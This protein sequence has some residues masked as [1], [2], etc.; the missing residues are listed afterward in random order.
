MKIKKID[1]SLIDNFN[2]HPFQVNHDG[3]LLELI[4]SIS[5]SGLLNPII[6]RIKGNRYEM[7]S[8]HR[9]KE[10]CECLGYEEIDA[11]VEDLTDDEAIIKMVDSNIQRERLLPSEK[12]FAYKMKMEALKHQGKKT[13]ATLLHKSRDEVSKKD[14]GETVRKY[15]RLTYLIPE[16][17]E[18]IDN[19][20]LYDKRQYLTMGIIIGV[21]LSYLSKEEQKLVY[22]TIT[23]VDATPT[24]GQAKKI[25][26][27][28]DNRTIDF[29]KLEQILIEKK[30]IQNDTI[31]FNKNKIEE[32]LPREILNRDKKY[33]ERYIIEAIKK[34]NSQ[35][36]LH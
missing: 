25:R 13:C 35:I 19:T 20:V 33:I 12:A 31:S 17:L 29:N 23:Y 10:A 34:F 1:I 15:I 2:N 3:S 7:I 4:E 22:N 30:G 6:V 8:G 28:S 18:L 14:S 16:I 36:N 27:L 9:R 11:F 5:Q 24:L 32:V 21:E 26:K